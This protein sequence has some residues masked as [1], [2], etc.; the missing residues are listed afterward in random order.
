MAEARQPSDEQW[1]CGT[2]GWTYDPAAGFYDGQSG[3]EYEP[4]TPWESLPDAIVCPD[5]GS[6]KAGFTKVVP[7]A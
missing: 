2:C 3:V 5:C 7:A 1:V 6:A 4:Y